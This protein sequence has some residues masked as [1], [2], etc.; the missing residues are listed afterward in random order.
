M[1]PYRGAPATMM[2]VARL[3]MSAICPGFC[4]APPRRDGSR[5]STPAVDRHRPSHPMAPGR[6]PAAGISRLN[7]AL[8]RRSTRGPRR[9]RGTAPRTS[10]SDPGQPLRGRRDAGRSGVARAPNSPWAVVAAEAGRGTKR[11]LGLLDSEARRGVAR[12]VHHRRWTRANALAYKSR[13][14]MTRPIRVSPLL[15]VNKKAPQMR[16]FWSVSAAIH[17]RPRL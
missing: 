16:F 6:A 14:R 5:S 3:R 13:R 11:V 4:V 1:C 17:S 15:R 2:F 12:L 10:R 7:R 8:A 9:P